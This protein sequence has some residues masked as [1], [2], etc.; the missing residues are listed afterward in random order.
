M[1]GHYKSNR[2]QVGTVEPTLVYETDL[3]RMYCGDSLNLLQGPE[4]RHLQRRTQLVFTSPPFPLNEKK[5]YGNLKGE[6]YIEWFSSFAPK[7]AETLTPNG[8]IVVEIGN[9]WEPGR[10]VM[11]TVVLRA[12]LT[13]LEAANLRLCQEFVWY[14]PARLPS[15]VQWVNVER[16]R[17]KDAFSKIWWMSTTDRPKANN[18]Q[19]LKPYSPSMRRLIET[20]RYNPGAR[21]SEHNIGLS[22][23]IKDNAGAIPP[24]V[25]GAD[26]AESLG[27]LLKGTNTRSSEQYQIFCRE[28]EIPLH[29]A[30]MPKELPEFFIK[31]L[32]DEGDLVFDPFGG[33][34]TTGAVAETLGRQWISCEA[35]LPYASSSLGRFNP[36]N[37]RVIGNVEVTAPSSAAA[38]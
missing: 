35:H 30:R 37:L 23:F 29:P 24:N 26:D 6:E 16:I 25:L 7:L 27:T 21:P 33:S 12:L 14:N 3:G 11:S 4:G 19:V 8:S 17:V 13:F 10:P 38:E 2:P 31:F 36:A 1:A 28:R 18:R 5:K 22:S 15:P 20:G 32:T 9:A 34:N